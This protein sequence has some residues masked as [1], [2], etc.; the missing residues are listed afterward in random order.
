MSTIYRNYRNLEKSIIDQ[1]TTLLLSD[2]W[3]VRVEKSFSEVY[4]ENATFPCICINLEDTLPE[5][6]EVGSDTYAEPATIS[7]RI[8]C[9]DDGSRLD[10]ASWCVSKIMLGFDYREYT[11]TSGVATYTKT[12]RITINKIKANRKELTNVERLSKEDR[13]RHIISF[14]CRI[15]LT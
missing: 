11:I 13:Y 14:T 5:R 6:I 10:L 15:S 9:K 12:G 3:S 1:V 7:F 2:N 8:F 4:A